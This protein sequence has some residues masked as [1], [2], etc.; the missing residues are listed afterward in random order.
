MKELNHIIFMRKI[1]QN[2]NYIEVLK[3]WKENPLKSKEE[4]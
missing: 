1:S 3:T 4:K 2:Q